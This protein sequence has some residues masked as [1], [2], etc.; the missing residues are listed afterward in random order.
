MQSLGKGLEDDGGSI[1]AGGTDI[2]PFGPPR[3]VED[4]V[5]SKSCPPSHEDGIFGLHT[6]NRETQESE[7][8]FKEFGRLT[9][10]GGRSRYV[11]NRFWVSLSEEV[12]LI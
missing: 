6:A 7:K 9:V 1:E 4:D 3:L 5:N 8:I 2:E 11:S 12:C 10:E